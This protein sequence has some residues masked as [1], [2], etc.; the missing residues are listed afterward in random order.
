MSTY[1][2][3]VRRESEA[4]LADAPDLEGVHTWAR[5]LR[6]L[7]RAIREAIALAEDLPDGAEDDLDIAFEYRTG[8]DL[9][10]AAA[11]LSDERHQLARQMARVERETAGMARQVTGG[12]RALSVRDAATLLRISPQRVS[13]LAPKSGGTS[14]RGLGESRGGTPVADPKSGQRKRG[15]S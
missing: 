15:N 4:W 3:V 11:R 12:S 1:R 8:D 7:H 10:D 13:Q 9:L 5:S 14:K 2:V 6:T